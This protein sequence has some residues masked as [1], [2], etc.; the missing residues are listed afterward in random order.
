[1]ARRGISL[2]IAGLITEAVY[3]LAAWRLPWWAFGSGSWNWVRILG[4]GTGTLLACLAGVLGLMAAYLWGWH[5]VRRDAGSRRMVWAFSILFAATLIWLLPMTSDLFN[6][7]TRA[8]L[9]T[10]LGANPLTDTPVEFWDPLVSAYPSSYPG[11][12]SIYGPVWVLLSAL[13]TLGSHDGVAGLFYLKS[14]AVV[15]YLA[16]VWLLERILRQVRPGSADEALYLFAWNP[17]VLLMA[18]GDGHNDIVMMAMIL[19]AIWLLLREKWTLALAILGLSAWV[20]VVSLVLFPLFVLYAWRQLERRSARER[21]AVLVRAALASLLVTILAFA[22]FG[23]AEGI[24]RIGERLLHP[25]NWRAATDQVASGVFAVGLFLFC[26][27]YAV[28]LVQF[29][30]AQGSVQL[31]GTAGFA[32]F[33]LAVLLGVARSQ[34]WH[35]IWPATLAGLADKR[36]AWPAVV[37]LSG[38]LLVVQF[39]VEWGTPGVQLWPMEV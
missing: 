30:R 12:T 22:P 15:A 18:I 21:W 34:P 19:L 13:G 36:W 29:V 9:F 25:A 20:K 33:L 3:L 31:L 32:A 27:A 1:M 28:L 6:Y 23:G 35:L 2:L 14:L 5:L 24:L 10:D 26:A 37:G 17:L 11:Q 16:A 8:H 38:L 4:E 7:L 39:W